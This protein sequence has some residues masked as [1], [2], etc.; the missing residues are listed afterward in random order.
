MTIFG[1]SAG[2]M[3]VHAHVLSPWNYGQ[4]QG[5]IAQ[6]G[7]M[8]YY[9]GLKTSGEERFAKHAAQD[10]FDCKQAATE[11]DQ[12]VLECLQSIEAETLS[13]KL[14]LDIDEYFNLSSATP[15]DWHPVI[16]TYA[17]NPFLPMDPLEAMKTGTFNRIP[18]MSGTVKNEGALMVGVFSSQGQRDT[19][20][21]YWSI[22]G[23]PLILSDS[24]REKFSTEEVLLS[25]I[26]HR[27]YN[28]PEGDTAVEKDQPLMDL[29]SDA[30]FLSPDQK[31]VEL[32]SEYSQYIFNY[33]MTQQ[34]DH[35]FLAKLFNQSKAYTP[36][37]A[38]D[39]IFLMPLY[40][41]KPDFS[42]EE[43]ALSEH[44]VKYWTNFAKFGHPSPSAQ[45]DL[46]FWAPVSQDHKVITWNM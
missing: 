37:H 25:N 28:H 12:S 34:T 7:T 9:K 38:D 13:D 44:M 17:E 41:N 4:I 18:F 21:E 16:D 43:S 14:S 23:P 31:T 11:L 5:A 29:L 19:L 3:S 15:W 2:G 40:G 10:I 27:Y 39:L 35:S 22:Y 26:S 32:M 1:E 6:S 46:P 42:A 8:L 30:T 33:Y 20:E 45:G 36:V 24:S